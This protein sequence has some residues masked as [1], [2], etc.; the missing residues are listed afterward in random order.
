MVNVNNFVHTNFVIYPLGFLTA[1][2]SYDVMP[3]LVGTSDSKN[4][5]PYYYLY[6][7]GLVS[8]RRDKNIHF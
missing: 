5:G 3:V 1:Y 4:P 2:K 6:N 8:F 7:T